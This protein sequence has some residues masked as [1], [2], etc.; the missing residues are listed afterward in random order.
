MEEYRRLSPLMACDLLRH[1][2]YAHPECPAIRLLEAGREARHRAMGL[3]DEEPATGQEQGSATKG[4]TG[5]EIEETVRLFDKEFGELQQ[6]RRQTRTLLRWQ[7]LKR[8]TKEEEENGRLPPEKKQILVLLYDRLT[9]VDRKKSRADKVSLSRCR[10]ALGIW[11]KRTNGGVNAADRSSAGG[12]LRPCPVELQRV[13]GEWIA[14]IDG[15]QKR[16]AEQQG[17]LVELLIAA[18]PGGLTPGELNQ[19]SGSSDARAALRDLCK[20]EAWKRV[21]CA[22]KDRRN[23]FRPKNDRKWRLVAPD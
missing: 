15:Q 13:D 23:M 5:T 11:P 19:K 18:F 7:L 20:D 14:V 9:T 21:L 10:F 12:A 17:L 3:Y 16:V 8:L 1:H 4:F 2:S 6:W 22:P